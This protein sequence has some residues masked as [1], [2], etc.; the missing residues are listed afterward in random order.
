MR[1]LRLRLKFGVG[2]TQ[3]LGIR[4]IDSG[5]ALAVG[6]WSSIEAVVWLLP[7]I[8]LSA[9]FQYCTSGEASS[10]NAVNVSS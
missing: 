9:L 6:E 2:M 3:A 1:I 4:G 7:W 8:C 5:P 10:L